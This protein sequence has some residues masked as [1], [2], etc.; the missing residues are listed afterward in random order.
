MPYKK[1]K[2][3]EYKNKTKKPMDKKKKPVKKKA[4]KKVKT[5]G[6][7]RKA[8]DSGKPAKKAKP[9]INSWIDD[10]AEES[11]DEGGGDDDDEDDDE[12]GEN[13]YIKDD[14]VVDDDVGL[15]HGHPSGRFDQRAPCR[16]FHWQRG[17]SRWT[18]AG[19]EPLFLEY[20]SLP[21]LDL[22]TVRPL[23]HAGDHIA[24]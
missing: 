23:L 14:F 18:A 15:G 9:S 2:V 19:Q 24:R 5:S 6:K 17:D 16:F 1:G 22:R 8:S 7:K 10:A 11:G 20:G 21:F 12:E 3:Q 13:D 4:S